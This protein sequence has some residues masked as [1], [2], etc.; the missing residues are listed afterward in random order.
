MASLK[1]HFYTVMQVTN[2]QNKI[3]GRLHISGI[4]TLHFNADPDIKYNCVFFG[5]IDI[6]PL[7]ENLPGS[8]E[9]LQAIYKTSYDHILKTFTLDTL[10]AKDDAA[11][12][13]AVRSEGGAVEAQIENLNP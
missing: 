9:V 7:L 8:D 2:S 3:V 12:E 1:K 6:L 5:G 11:I 10:A 4:V 13:D